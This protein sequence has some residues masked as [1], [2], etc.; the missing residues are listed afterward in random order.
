MQQ[1]AHRPNNIIYQ[2][3]PYD[4]FFRAWVEFLS[5][6]HH[7]ASREKDVMAKIIAQ[8]F[9]LKEQCDDPV[10][11]RELL[12]SQSSRQDMRISLGMEPS[13]FQMVLGKL[14]KVGVLDRGDINHRYLPHLR[15]ESKS[16]E[17]R[18][19]FDFSTPGTP[20]VPSHETVAE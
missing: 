15:P 12:W 17:L 3:C 8:Y 11:L 4:S 14:R 19:V 1:I 10:M 6:Y 20:E 13:H 16:F 9:R 2:K 18:I 7:L 5:P